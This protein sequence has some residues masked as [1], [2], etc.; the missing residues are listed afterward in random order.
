MTYTLT[1]SRN[2]QKAIEICNTF[3]CFGKHLRVTQ[4]DAMGNVQ[5]YLNDKCRTCDQSSRCLVLRQLVDTWMN[6]EL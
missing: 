6:N 4:P 5:P 3:T 2:E 1:V